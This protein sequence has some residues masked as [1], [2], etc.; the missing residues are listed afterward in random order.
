M[1]QAFP[2]ARGCNRKGPDSSRSSPGLAEPGSGWSSSGAKGNILLQCLRLRINILRSWK[3]QIPESPWLPLPPARVLQKAREV[4]GLSTGSA[5]SK[6]L[7]PP[8]PQFP[9]LHNGGIMT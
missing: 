5:P 7:V 4:M 6:V 2:D 8:K 3:G 1:P 9:Y